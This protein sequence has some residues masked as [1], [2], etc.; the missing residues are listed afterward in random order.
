MRPESL[1]FLAAGESDPSGALAGRVAKRRYG[2]PLTYYRVELEHGLENGPEH[3]EGDGRLEVEV[4]A[5]AGAA[6]EGDRVRVAPAGAGAPPLRAFPAARPADAPP[7]P[8]EPA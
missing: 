3:H 8:R 2:G 7:P 6:A 1:R 5:D 4:L